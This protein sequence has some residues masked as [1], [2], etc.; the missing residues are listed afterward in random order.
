MPGFVCL[1]LVRFKPVINAGLDGAIQ[2]FQRGF[3]KKLQIFLG[4]RAYKDYQV[5]GMTKSVNF[6]RKFSIFMRK[7]QVM[8]MMDILEF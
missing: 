5:T 3:G 6:C 7:A 1:D 8:Y 2:R 4:E